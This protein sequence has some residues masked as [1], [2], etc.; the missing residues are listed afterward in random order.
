MIDL[1]P[2]LGLVLRLLRGEPVTPPLPRCEKPRP[3]AVLVPTMRGDE[4]RCSR[5][6]PG[7]PCAGANGGGGTRSKTTGA[8]L[9]RPLLISKP[10]TRRET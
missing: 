9:H 6:Q 5:R 3:C 2:A 10:T 1:L 4:W 7:S 8:G